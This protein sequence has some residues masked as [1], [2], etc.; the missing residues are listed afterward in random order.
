VRDA[1]AIFGVAR[2][3]FASN[4]PVDSLGA[5]F[6]VIYGAFGKLSADRSEPERR[7]LF[8]DNARRIY[9]MDEAPAR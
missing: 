1:L 7:A 2:C 5:S 4:Y 6:D 9:R 8:A 3:L